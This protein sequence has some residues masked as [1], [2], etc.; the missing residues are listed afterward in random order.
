MCCLSQR[1]SSLKWVEYIPMLFSHMML[2]TVKMIKDAAG[3]KDD[4][5]GTRE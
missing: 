4:F 3:R 5:N 1:F 2:K